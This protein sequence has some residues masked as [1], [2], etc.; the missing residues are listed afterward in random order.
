MGCV[1]VQ[2]AAIRTEMIE[3]DVEMNGEAE[4]M[5]PVHQSLQVIGRAVGRGGREGQ[6]AVIAP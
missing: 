6:D 1:G 4:F 5:R 3:H 2:I